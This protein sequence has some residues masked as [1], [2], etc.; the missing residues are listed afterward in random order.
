[1][2]FVKKIFCCE[3]TLV[4]ETLLERWNMFSGI[5]TDMTVATAGVDSVATET[6]AGHMINVR[7]GQFRDLRLEVIQPP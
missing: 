6:C 2:V 1:M 4:M 3:Y 5:S 7:A